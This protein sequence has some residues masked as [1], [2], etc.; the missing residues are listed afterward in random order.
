MYEGTVVRTFIML[1]QEPPVTCTQSRCP[2]ACAFPPQ[3]HG[4]FLGEGPPS[5]LASSAELSLTFP[6]G[7]PSEGRSGAS[8]E[9][10]GGQGAGMFLAHEA[11]WQLGPP[12]GKLRG[13]AGQGTQ[14][15]PAR[16]A[17]QV[18]QGGQ[19]NQGVQGGQGPQH[20]SS[21]FRGERQGSGGGSTKSG[22]LVVRGS[23][24]LEGCGSALAGASGTVPGVSDTLPS[25]S[26]TLP[27]VS[28]TL[29]DVSGTLPGV[30]GTLP[31]ASSMAASGSGTLTGVSGTLP[32][33]SGTLTGVSSYTLSPF[34]AA[35]SK[36]V[37]AEYSLAYAGI[38]RLGSDENA[39]GLPL[40]PSGVV[41][42]G[43]R[44]E[45]QALRLGSFRCV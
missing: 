16:Q 5:P 4:N 37:S 30:S 8:T 33:T 9:T 39:A 1:P 2:F 25:V 15:A 26:G 31:G 44:Q 40:L 13:Q 43:P 10:A 20:P 28:S 27:A 21:R 24:T 3:E 11:V 12:G 22:P 45:V 38:S 42:A 35:S 34:L 41:E 36:Q 14:S 19:A 18:G 29:P 23:G 32:G 7:Q 6:M 17:G